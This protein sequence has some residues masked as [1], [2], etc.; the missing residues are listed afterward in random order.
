MLCKQFNFYEE[1]N[2]L[3]EIQQFNSNGYLFSLT[4]V[5]TT[6]LTIFFHRPSSQFTIFFF[7]L[8]IV[9]HVDSKKS[10]VNWRSDKLSREKKNHIVMLTKFD[11]LLQQY[12]ANMLYTISLVS[13]Y[14]HYNLLIS[15]FF[16]KRNI[17][18]TLAKKTKEGNIKSQLNCI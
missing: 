10:I 5:R 7:T 6:H 13:Y 16:S 18:P 14:S 15:V 2:I 12:M 8:Y 9:N 4:S 11:G 3:N 1:I 17:L